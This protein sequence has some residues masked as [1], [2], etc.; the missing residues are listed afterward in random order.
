MTGEPVETGA[1]H[2]ART[3]PS[4]NSS[5]GA[6]GA[7]GTASGRAGADAGLGSDQST[8]FCAATVNVYSVSLVRL[9]IVH[10]VLAHGRTMSPGLATTRYPVIGAPRLSGASHEST[11]VRSRTSTTRGAVGVAGLPRTRR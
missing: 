1:S 10:V 2:V 4:P 9:S 3:E 11:T 5:V 7:S 8:A 6:A